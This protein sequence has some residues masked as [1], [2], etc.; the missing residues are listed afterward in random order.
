[1]DSYATVRDIAWSKR[2]E[3]YEFRFQ[4]HGHNYVWRCTEA[5]RAECLHAVTLDAHNRE[6]NLSLVDAVFIQDRIREVIQPEYCEWVEV[7][8][9][10]VEIAAEI[11]FH[12]PDVRWLGWILIVSGATWVWF[13]S[14]IVRALA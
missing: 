8:A 2:D 6:L 5:L 14:L 4:K 12:P 9:A 3:V 1:M 10:P 13:I 7:E 11:E